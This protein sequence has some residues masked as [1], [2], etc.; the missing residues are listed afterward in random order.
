MFLL[1]LTNRGNAGMIETLADSVPDS[2]PEQSTGKPEPIR[3]NV[4]KF[5]PTPMLLWKKVEN[6]TFSYE[7]LIGKEMSFSVQAGYLTFP[8]ILSD[9]IAGLVTITGGKKY[10]VNLAA[11]YRYYPLSRNRRPAPDGLYLG[12]YVSYY[13]FNFSNDLDI[14]GTTVD[15]NG[16]LYGRL[17]VVNL[18]ISVGY[19]FIFWKRLSVDL[20]MFGPAV[21]YYQGTLGIGGDLDPGQIEDIDEELVNALL[22]Q[23][24]WLGTLFTAQK[25]EFTGSQTKFSAG[26]RF[27]IQVGFHF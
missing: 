16:T 17:N 21:S 18:G 10:G 8:K 24:P 5:N 9:T 1:L 25:L 15:Q 23:F 3:R 12:G 11:D 7:R 20:L 2:N 14:L 13:G 22:E 6:I 27:S 26:L 19:Q 4:I